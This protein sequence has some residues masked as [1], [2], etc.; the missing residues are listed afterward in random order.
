[1]VANDPHEQLPVGQTCLVSLSILA[2]QI[3]TGQAVI[4]NTTYCRASLKIPNEL[5]IGPIPQKINS[6]FSCKTY[7]NL[8]I[9]TTRHKL[10][11][12]ETIFFLLVV[13]FGPSVCA[14]NTDPYQLG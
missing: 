1:M 13:G 8:F 4:F 10:T 14:S 9:E 3:A 6:K 7:Y 11:G 2:D 5:S 12:M